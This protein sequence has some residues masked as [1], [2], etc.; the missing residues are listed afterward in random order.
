MAAARS[1][2]TAAAAA[3]VEGGGEAV[4]RSS[5]S[6]RS[7]AW[8][9]LPAERRERHSFRSTCFPPLF[10]H[11]TMIRRVINTASK[12]L[13]RSRC[14][15]HMAAAWNGRN[16]SLHD[17]CGCALRST[18]VLQVYGVNVSPLT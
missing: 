7:M 13:G 8:A 14:M 17:V 1:G 9:W 5:S 2:L 3:A 18:T 11:H 6:A 15:R 12:L 10:I 4:A 16:V